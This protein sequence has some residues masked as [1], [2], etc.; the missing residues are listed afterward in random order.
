MKILLMSMPDVAALIMHE[1]AFHM[2]NLRHCQRWGEYRRG[3]RDLHR[4]PHPQAKTAEALSDRHAAEDPPGP[5]RP[6]C[7]GVAVQDLREDHPAR[8][9]TAPE[10]EDHDR[11]LSCQPDVRGDCRFRGGR[12]D[13]LHGPG[14]RGGGVSPP[15][16]C[17]WKERIVWKR[18][19][20]SPTRWTGVL[21]TT[22]G[23]SFW[24]FPS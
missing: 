22:R 12:V 11:R 1:S 17:D 4:R 8:Q 9:A 15:G 24:I 10:C 19:H 14:G 13:R 2:P 16:Q 3:S 18:S 5:G 23:V 7:H 20:H 6:L 21:F